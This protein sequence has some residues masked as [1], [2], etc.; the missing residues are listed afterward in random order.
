MSKKFL[1]EGSYEIQPGSGEPAPPDLTEPEGG[2]EA[3]ARA[4][5]KVNEKQT[6]EAPPQLIGK[7]LK[8][9]VNGK[10]DPR[11][12][13]AR[14]NK[15]S[16]QK[17]TTCLKM[18]VRTDMDR[19]L[20]YP[21]N[22]TNPSTDEKQF[23]DWHYVYEAQNEELD[24][25]IPAVGDFVMV[26]YPW[27]FGDWRSTV[28]IYLGKTKKAFASTC[29]STKSNFDKKKQ[30]VGTDNFGSNNNNCGGKQTNVPQTK[31]PP[32]PPNFGDKTLRQGMKKNE[33]V[34]TLQK[35]LNVE[36]DGKFGP[37]T[38]KAVEGFQRENGLQADGVVGPNTRAKLQELHAIGAAHV[39]G[40]KQTTP[41]VAAA[42]EVNVATAQNVAAARRRPIRAHM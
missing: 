7:V 19:A 6:K 20:P 31:P 38:K 29:K 37:K 17:T 10:P 25:I 28:G 15:L 42:K 14:A 5:K 2:L 9:M 23:I 35:A 12:P 34:V 39:E 22:F 32:S 26:Q 21:C 8:V 18:I 11:G 36:P 41:A 3:F 27:S 33:H 16:S 13:R 1:T 40:L 24:K 4:A 30:G